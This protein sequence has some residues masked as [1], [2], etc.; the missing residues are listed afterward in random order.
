M[1]IHLHGY[2]IEAQISPTQPVSMV[3]DADVA[4]RFTVEKHGAK[5]I[6]LIYLEV[7]PK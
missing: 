7:Y 4:G 5:E 6:S 2:D 1:A 3:F